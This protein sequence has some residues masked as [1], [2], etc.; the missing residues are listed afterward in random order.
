M[1]RNQSARFTGNKESTNIHLVEDDG[2]ILETTQENT[3]HGYIDRYI[4]RYT[5]QYIN[6]H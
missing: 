1:S 6:L 5:E 3:Y 4:P 2:E